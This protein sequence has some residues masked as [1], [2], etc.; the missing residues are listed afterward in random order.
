[1][2]A[3]PKGPEVVRTI[4]SLPPIVLGLSLLC[5]SS[6]TCDGAESPCYRKWGGSLRVGTSYVSNPYTRGS[7]L[8]L[9]G[10]VL[11]HIIG[12][13]ESGLDL[14]YEGL[15][16]EDGRKFNAM[17]GGAILRLPIGSAAVQPYLL[18]GLGAYS[19]KQHSEVFVTGKS[20]SVKAGVVGGGG[21]LFRKPRSSSPVGFGIDFR[22]HSLASSTETERLGRRVERRSDYWV[23]SGAVVLSSGCIGGKGHPYQ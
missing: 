16:S 13:L 11:F 17:H 2:R 21:L 9:G 19:V 3:R 18:A 7:D 8:S 4:I 6:S 10:E 1:M 12:P 20:R 22:W 5:A 23:A 15:T 14:G